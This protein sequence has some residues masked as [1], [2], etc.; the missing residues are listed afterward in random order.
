MNFKNIKKLY[1][2]AIE[3]ILDILEIELNKL[4]WSGDNKCHFLAQCSH[5]S[6]GFRRLTENLNYSVEGLK[7]I[8]PKYFR[9]KNPEDYAR[10]PE[11]IANLVYANRMGNGDENSGEG[12]KYR[13]RGIIQITG[14]NNYQKCLKDLE[15]SD[16]EFLGTIEGAVLS[17]IWFWESNSLYKEHDITIIT[18]RVNGGI[19]GLNDRKEHYNKIKEC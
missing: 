12:W 1:P 7:K 19:N 15:V 9:D 14:K 10:K 2:N 17:A 8:F 18:K 3:G 4:D 16:P 6:G 5:E 13:G 11:K